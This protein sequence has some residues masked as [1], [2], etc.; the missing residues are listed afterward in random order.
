MD[1][2][3]GLAFLVPGHEAVL[4][5]LGPLCVGNEEPVRQPVLLED[6]SISGTE[7]GMRSQ[8]D[9]HST[10]SK[11]RAAGQG[12]SGATAEGE[13]SARCVLGFGQSPLCLGSH[14]IVP[15]T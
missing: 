10:L 9:G 4:A 1:G 13:L 15:V 8:G 2:Q 6:H 7:L 5:S 14:L 11:A 3:R 12:L